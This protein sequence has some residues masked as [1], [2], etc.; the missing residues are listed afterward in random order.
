MNDADVGPFELDCQFVVRP[1]FALPASDE[2]LDRQGQIVDRV[3]SEDQAIR[4]EPYRRLTVVAEHAASAVTARVKALSERSQTWCG[5]IGMMELTAD[6]KRVVA[7]QQLGFIA[8]VTPDGRPNLSPKGTTVVID[9]SHLLFADVAS[10]NTVRNLSGNPHIEINVVDPILRK[11]YRF[12]GKA[13]VHA[14]DD[15]YQRGLTLLRE[16]GS[17]LTSDRVRSIVVVEV[18]EAAALVSPAYHQD[19][20]EQSVAANWLAKVAQLYRHRF[21]S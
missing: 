3:F 15:W 1:R 17:S 6:M 21:G 12:K 4:G 18:V 2:A 19:V 14:D 5:T 11:G 7:E 20:S 10:P 8:T 9:D 13:A 16:Q